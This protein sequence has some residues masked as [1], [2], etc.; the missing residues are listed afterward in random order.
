M[1]WPS[2][3]SI[4]KTMTYKKTNNICVVYNF[5]YSVYPYCIRSAF[6]SKNKF[7]NINFKNQKKE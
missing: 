6:I 4:S 1:Y 2:R 3:D 7:V 5:I